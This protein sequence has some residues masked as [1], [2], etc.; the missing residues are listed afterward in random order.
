MIRKGRFAV[1]GNKEFELI[2]YQRQYYLQSENPLDMENGFVR[3]NGEKQ[4]FIK[5]VS[6]R[7]LED[8]Y[9]IVPY[10]M[11]AGYRFSLEGYNEKTGKVALVTNNSFVKEKV[12]VQAYGKFEYIIE[13][14]LDEIRLEEDRIPIRDFE[15]LHT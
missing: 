10:A 14:S 8:A 12:D 15:G 1:W 9:E 13:V 7:E 5:P 3:K 6:I 11:I 2:S 4:I